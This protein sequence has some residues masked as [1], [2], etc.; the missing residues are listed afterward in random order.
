MDRTQG[1]Q[2]VKYRLY[3]SAT[4]STLPLT[5]KERVCSSLR[6]FVATEKA[7]VVVSYSRF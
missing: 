1:P 5:F 7:L 4:L 6:Y 2:H 3:H